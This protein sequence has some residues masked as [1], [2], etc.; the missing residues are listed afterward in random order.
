MWQFY[1]ITSTLIVLIVNVDSLNN[2]NICV[3]SNETST[4]KGIRLMTDMPAAISE[5]ARIVYLQGAIDSLSFKTFPNRIFE[6]PSWR[7]VFTLTL[8][9]F[10]FVTQ[11]EQ[12][13]FAGLENLKSLSILR[14]VSL[15]EINS[16]AFDTTPILKKLD[17]SF[18]PALSFSEVANAITE[19]VPHLDHLSLVGLNK[20]S[21]VPYVIGSTF[22]AALANKRLT[23]LDMSNANFASLDKEIIMNVFMN[24]RFLNLSFTIMAWMPAHLDGSMPELETLDL[25]YCLYAPRLDLENR[26]KKKSNKNKLGHNLSS[27]KY[28]YVNGLKQFDNFRSRNGI[29][30]EPGWLN[31]SLE[32]FELRESDIRVINVTI[33]GRLDK[34]RKLDM[35]NGEFEFISPKFFSYFAPMK[36]L[37][38]GGNRLGKMEHMMEFHEL[39]SHLHQLEWLN[40]DDNELTFVPKRL[41]SSNREIKFLDLH[42]NHLNNLK[43]DIMHLH[44]LKYLDLSENRLRTLPVEITAAL[45]VVLAKQSSYFV[46]TSA[47]NISSLKQIRSE[48]HRSEIGR[49]VHLGDLPDILTV[50]I[51]GNPLECSCDNLYFVEWISNTRVN[52]VNRSDLTCHFQEAE[53]TLNKEGVSRLQYHCSKLAVIIVTSISVP[54]TLLIGLAIVCCLKRRCCRKQSRRPKLAK[55]SHA[56]Y[57]ANIKYIRCDSKRDM[58]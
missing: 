2:D 1:I 31:P 6:D 30:L 52:L 58:L 33:L 10:K 50:D 27:L 49:P 25:S 47:N 36:T 38:L 45:D 26:N 35:S 51:T 8:S 12:H 23:Y 19:K 9:D 29:T 13:A 37:M 53:L 43:I 39:L 42:A 14:F 15:R 40:L 4:C 21:I 34:F 5:S 11:I 56:T 55:D 18:N 20:Q 54:V 24:L 44:N 17:L 57:E 41:F 22:K 48:S 46:V 32:Y 16:N 7:N 28:L 3:Q